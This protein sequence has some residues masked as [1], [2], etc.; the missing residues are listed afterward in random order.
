MSTRT[1]PITVKP[2]PPDRLVYATGVMLDAQDFEAEQLYHR[3]RLARALAYTQ[4]SGTVAGLAVAWAPNSKDAD[5]NDVPGTD[6]VI[7][8]AGM[9][10]DRLGRIIEVPRAACLR[11]T[12]WYDAQT[13]TALAES[14]RHG[15]QITPDVLTRHVTD[16]RVW[17]SATAGTVAQLI[18][19][20]VVDVF[21]RFVACE[22]G[23][24][25]AFATGP[26]DALD[27][28]QPSRLRDGYELTL[29]PRRAT[30]TDLPFPLARWT[31]ITGTTP[32]ERRT[33]VQ[34]AILAAW[35][36]QSDWDGDGLKHEREQFPTQDPTALFLARLVLPASVSPPSMRPER[37][38]GTTVRVDNHHRAF[39]YPAGALAEALPWVVPVVN[40]PPVPAP[41]PTP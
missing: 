41:V 5:G 20:V 9:A 10:I 13:D 11:L 36:E 35:R 6:R 30:P 27:A 21:L 40:E 38:N 7:V 33:S 19:G 31:S 22:R 17:W 24:T 8:E 14:Y 1:D 26:F 37:D 23:K 25:P 16:G 18:D 15:V 39:V 3:G 2:E 29:V 28:V 32:D 34:D 12:N 4:G